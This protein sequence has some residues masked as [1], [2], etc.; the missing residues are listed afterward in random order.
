MPTPPV[1]NPIP[2]T[3]AAP[4]KKTKVW[5]IVLIVVLVLCC[6]CVLVVVLAFATFSASPEFQ[7]IFQN[8]GTSL[9]PILQAVI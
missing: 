3:P 5:L 1:Y 4:P 7:N 6:C 8:F 2:E 9:L